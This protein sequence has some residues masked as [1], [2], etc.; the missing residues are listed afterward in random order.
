MTNTDSGLPHSGGV[1]RVFR[2][3]APE[4][5]L[6]V[7]LSDGTVGPRNTVTLSGLVLSTLGLDVGDHEWTAQYDPGP[8]PTNFAGSVSVPLDVVVSPARRRPRSACRWPLTA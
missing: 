1:V 8:V 5:V 4:F 2:D 7:P 3:S 6:E